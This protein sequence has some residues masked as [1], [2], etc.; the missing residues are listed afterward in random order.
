MFKGR[1][2]ERSFYL[3]INL[4]TQSELLGAVKNAYTMAAKRAAVGYS[5]TVSVTSELL[6]TIKIDF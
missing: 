4:K 3:D 6:I 2:R 5:S 1:E